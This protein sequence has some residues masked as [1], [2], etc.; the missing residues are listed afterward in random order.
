[1]LLDQLVENVREPLLRWEL[2]K[3]GSATFIDIRDLAIK[4]STETAGG[5]RRRI[6]SQ[7]MSKAREDC[8]LSMLTIISEQQK[9]QIRALAG[10]PQNTERTIHSEHWQGP[11]RTLRGPP[12]QSTGGATTEHREGHPL[13]ALAWPPSN[14]ERT[15]HL[16]HWRGHHRTLRGPST[17]PRET[18]FSVV[19]RVSVLENVGQYTMVDPCVISVVTRET[20]SRSVK[21]MSWLK[22]RS[23]I[24]LMF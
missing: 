20:Y 15:I 4:W 21:H 6:A 17:P 22:T 16:E 1:M 24:K 5:S 18:D 23:E 11:H 9:Q 14:T 10:P 12:T 3:T 13:R 2:K 7:E 19:D 8:V